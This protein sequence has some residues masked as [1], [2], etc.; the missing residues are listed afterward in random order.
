MRT[1]LKNDDD[2][3]KLVHT[4]YDKVQQDD[5]LGYIFNEAADVDWDHHLPKMV[6]FWSN[7]IFGTGRYRGRP[8]RQHVPLPIKRDDFSRWYNHFEQTVDDLFAGE[9]A[10]YAKKVARSVA[11]SFAMRMEMDGKFD[12]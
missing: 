10:E 5:R 11:Q 3:R 2:I 1:D 7:I 9:R 8:Y 6:D 12:D 4:F